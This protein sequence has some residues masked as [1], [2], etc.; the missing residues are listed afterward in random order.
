M[1]KVLIIGAG[2]SG[3]I[4]AITASKNNEVILLD[5]NDKAGK[6]ILLTGNGRCNYWNDDICLEQYETD[7]RENLE[8]VLSEENKS[9]V[10]NFLYSLSIY[11]KIKNG[12]YYPYSNQATSIVEILKKEIKNRK[13]DFR[14]RT[15]VKD[16]NK[17]NNKFASRW[18]FLLAAVGSAVGMANVWGFPGK[19]VSNGGGAFLIAYLIFIALFSTIGLAAEYAIG[20]RARTGTLGSY[21]NAWETRGKVAGKVGGV[22][23]WLPLIGSMCIAIGYAVIIAYVLK[24]LFTSVTGQIMTVDPG[25][26]F[27]SFSLT[28]FSVIPFHMIV[29]VVTLLT[30]LLGAKSI[31]KTNKVMMPVFFIIF[32]VLA[33]RVAFLDGASAGYAFMFKPDW[34]M[35]KDPMVWVS[36]MGQAFFSLSVTGSGMLVYGSPVSTAIAVRIYIHGR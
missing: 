34:S 26:W 14:A 35:L 10:L 22:I 27:E 23:G 12:Y 5:G 13:I 16:I 31:E 36:A 17:K 6:K 11:P 32:I 3:I 29:V 8:K 28:E 33:V 2:A 18:G 1:S 30:L 21:K 7:S 24:G 20:R 15:R 4:A 9:T 25:P 19:M